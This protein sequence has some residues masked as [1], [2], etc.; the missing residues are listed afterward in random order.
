MSLALGPI[1]RLL[2][3]SLYTPGDHGASS[4]LCH[5]AEIKAEIQFWQNN[6]GQFNGQD[7][8]PKPSAVRVVY[9]DASNTGYGEYTVEHGG[10]IANEMWSEEETAQSSTWREL[11]AVRRILE[12]FVH[13]LQNERVRWFTDNQTVVRI[14]LHGRKKPALQ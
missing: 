2:T 6:I 11:R 13:N 14:V 7:L 3:R 10:Q 5:H 1:T 8:W 4:W 12:S 9:S